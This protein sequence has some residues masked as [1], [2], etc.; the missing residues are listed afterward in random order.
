MGGAPAS[1]HGAR[2]RSGVLGFSRVSSGGS[3]GRPLG[4]DRRSGFAMRTQTPVWRIR[5]VPAPRS[6]MTVPLGT[7]VSLHNCRPGAAVWTRGSHF[8]A[9]HTRAV[10][11]RPHPPIPHPRLPP[12][13][14]G[15]QPP[16][17]ASAPTKPGPAAS[18]SISGSQGPVGFG[19]PR[20]AAGDGRGRWGPARPYPIVHKIKTTGCVFQMR[21]KSFGNDARTQATQGR[22]RRR[23]GPCGARSRRRNRC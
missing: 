13:P 8:R 18:T 3:R 7:F 19:C 16:G 6:L 11:A 9:W 4:S 2:L 21:G 14:R 10:R 17:R 1:F 12:S 23:N 5:A 20:G 22:K 15:S